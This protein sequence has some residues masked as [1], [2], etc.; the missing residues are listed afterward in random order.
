[1][2]VAGHRLAR[3]LGIPFIFAPLHHPR[4]VGRRYQVYLDLYREADAL[5]ALTAH[6]RGL[7]EALG[8]A[9]ERIS[10]IGIGPVLPQAADG[11]RFRAAHA[12][13]GQLVLFLGQ[14]YPY[15]GYEHLL[16]AAHLVWRERPEVTFAFL[17]PRTPASRRAFSRVSDPRILELDTVDLQTK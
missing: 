4:W 11:A 8:I 10:S 7:Y 1:L 13:P 5:I 6:E 2:Y 3:R 14:K 15:K 9:R 12:V 16:A 17:G